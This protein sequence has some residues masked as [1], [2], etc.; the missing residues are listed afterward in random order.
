MRKALV[1]LS[2]TAAIVAT[3]CSGGANAEAL[4][5][6]SDP[7]NDSST[8]QVSPQ[9]EKVIVRARKEVDRKVRYNAT[10]LKVSFENGKDRGV[11]VYPGGDIDPTVSSCTDLVVRAFRASG[12]D[13]QWRV[14][15]DIM[16]RREAY[17]YMVNPDTTVDHRR[18]P[19]L[20][21][22]FAGHALTLPLSVKDAAASFHPGD[23]VIAAWKPCP[24][25][26]PDHIGIVSDKIGKRT[27]LPMVIHNGGPAAK[28]EDALD[29]WRIIGH[30]RLDLE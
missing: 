8:T 22:Y 30:Y 18:V 6:S 3:L 20:Q 10:H 27:G 23:V 19:N 4:R 16:E 13:L 28:E 26:T 14:H 29:Q 21:N 7:R 24:Q 25:C 1:L 5:T 15:E 11:N 12:V 17:P 9:V 2:V